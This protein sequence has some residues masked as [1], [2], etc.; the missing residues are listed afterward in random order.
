MVADA[1]EG[2]NLGT[3]SIVWA[4]S[5]LLDIQYNFPYTSRL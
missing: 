2:Y 3:Q 4:L 1:R 5:P